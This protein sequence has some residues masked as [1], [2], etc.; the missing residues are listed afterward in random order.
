MLPGKAVQALGTCLSRPAGNQVSS[1]RTCSAT[2]PDE[3]SRLFQLIA[4]DAG[5]AA[6]VKLALALQFCRGFKHRTMRTESFEV[7]ERRFTLGVVEF[8]AILSCTFRLDF[9]R[10]LPFPLTEFSYRSERCSLHL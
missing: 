3:V 6:S 1:N 9:N 10:A 7:F 2:Q 4:S 8:L 5:F